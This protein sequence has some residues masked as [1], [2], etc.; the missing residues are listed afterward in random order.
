MARSVIGRAAGGRCAGF[1]RALQCLVEEGD[2][3]GELDVD[4]LSYDSELI[5][6]AAWPR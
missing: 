1:E 3:H 4:A 2:G 6:V 5:Q